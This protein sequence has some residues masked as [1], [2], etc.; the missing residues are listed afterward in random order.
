MIRPSAPTANFRVQ[1]CTANS[2]YGTRKSPSRLSSIRMKSLPKPWHLM[3]GMGRELFM[4][5][6]PCRQVSMI[7]IM[8]DWTAS[9][10]AAVSAS[11]RSTRIGWVLEAR[12]SPQ[13][14]G[15]FTRTP[16]MSITS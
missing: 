2:V 6:A 1:I 14:W 12:T 11:K 9:R 8:S 15:N 3:K 13:P 7:P 10:W 4:S 5:G 16:S